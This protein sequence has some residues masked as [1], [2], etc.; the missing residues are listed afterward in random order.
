MWNLVRS[1]GSSIGIALAVFVVT[2]MSS[3]SR[4]D[5]VGHVSHFNEAFLYPRNALWGTP[6]AGQSLAGL[7]AEITR[8]A[9]MI[10]YINVFYATAIVAAITVPFV[11][12]LATKRE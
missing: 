8:Q 10:G 4:A 9:L 6:D 12:L 2:R 7:N 1:A 5:I 11:L 3:V